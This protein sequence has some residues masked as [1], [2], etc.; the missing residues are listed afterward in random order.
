MRPDKGSRGVDGIE[1]DEERIELLYST[2]SNIRS[3]CALE[4]M[5]VATPAAVAISAAMSFVSIPPVPNFDPSVLV[6]TMQ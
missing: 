2:I 4:E 3:G 1:S 5:T 6:L